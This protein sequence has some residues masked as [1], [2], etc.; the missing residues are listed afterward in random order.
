MSTTPNAMEAAT[1]TATAT[2]TAVTSEKAPAPATSTSSEQTP[3]LAAA[4]EAGASSPP[5]HWSILI[6][7]LLMGFV[8]GFAIQKCEVYLPFR[9]VNQFLLRDF[10]VRVSVFLFAV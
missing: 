3:I 8:F 4:C 2:T 5:P 10:T 7:G 6:V 9:I 1:T